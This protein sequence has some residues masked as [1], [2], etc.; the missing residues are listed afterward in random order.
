MNLGTTKDQILAGIKIIILILLLTTNQ[1]AIM[2]AFILLLSILLTQ[3]KWIADAS[4]S[5]FFDS[6]LLQSIE[7]EI[8]GLK[9]SEY[10]VYL[11]KINKIFK[12]YNVNVDYVETKVTNQLIIFYYK[13]GYAFKAGQKRFTKIADV[14]G[15]LKE[16]N[17]AL[18]TECK[19]INSANKIGISIKNPNA[20]TVLFNELYKE[21][22]YKKFIKANK[23]G[24]PFFL[25]TNVDGEV[26]SADLT[27]APHILIAGE[28]NSGKST[29]LHVL[30]TSLML[31]KKP[32]E[33]KLALADFKLVELSVYK[34]SKY[35]YTPVVT[36]IDGFEVMLN[37][38]LDEMEDRLALFEKLN[39][40]NLQEFN[41]ITDTPLPY[42]LFV[43][44]ELA[45]VTLMDNK[46]LKAELETKLARL[47]SKCRAVG[48]NIII[49]VQKANNDIIPST[50]KTNIPS[51]L[52]LK[53]ESDAD[54][55]LMIGSNKAK[56]LLGQGDAIFKVD[57]NQIRLQCAYLSN[58]EHTKILGDR[59]N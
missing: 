37:K 25:G 6:D 3:I 31:N 44:E 8:N 12:Q 53:V 43:L 26:I 35:L 47:I 52:A 36:T 48:I 13:L 34:N 57:N 49:T 29:A 19:L 23:K 11:Q 21:P 41:E 28:T 50:I 10:D 2:I 54:S 33:L 5:T 22:A 39:V 24:L 42:I 30:I 7:D 59:L 38:L 32:A 46:K 27:K 14:N 40:K 1:S 17:L 16:I 45:S 51:R 56:D 4:S 55:R 9:Q 58:A 20:Q 18:D 15:V